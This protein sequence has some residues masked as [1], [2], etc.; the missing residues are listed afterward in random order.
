MK[1]EKVK[2]EEII[3]NPNNPRIIKNDKFKK[4]VK[5]IKEFPEMLEVRPIV[6][7]DDM[8]VLG[9]NMR[10]KACIEAGL[11][12]VSIIK[13]SN[14][15]EDRKKE[16]IVK[17]NVGYGEWDY[18]LLL[19]DWS[20]GQLLDWGIDIPSNNKVDNYSTKIEAP[21]YNP[22]DNKPLI[23]DLYSDDK[24]SSLLNEIDRSDVD[25]VTKGFLK[26]A[27]A[28]HIVFDYSKI[29]D[30]YANS[31]KNIQGLMESSALIIIDFDKAIEQ[32]FIGLSEDIKKQYSDE[33]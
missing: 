24:Y 11:K 3:L 4:L 30:F 13:F 20:K 29:A 9:G 21:I 31:D 10:T 5:S 23:E 12:E 28:R 16:F 2:I 19:E 1:I 25:D 15:S 14:L 32:G 8:V 17:D 6:V 26:M 18:D 33:N 7:G 27:A 22:S